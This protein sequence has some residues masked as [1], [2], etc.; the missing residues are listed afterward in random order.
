MTRSSYILTAGIF[1]VAYASLWPLLYG[2]P[3]FVR[4]VMLRLPESEYDHFLSA[5]GNIGAIFIML[6]TTVAP[7]YA[8]AYSLRN[9]EHSELVDDRSTVLVDLSVAQRIYQIPPCLMLSALTSQNVF[10]TLNLAILI[11]IVDVVGAYVHSLL[12]PEK[13]LFGVKARLKQWAIRKGDGWGAD[14]VHQ[15][16]AYL[17]FVFAAVAS[18]YVAVVGN[19]PASNI[20]VHLQCFFSGNWLWFFAHG[21]KPSGATLFVLLPVAGCLLEIVSLKSGTSDPATIALSANALCLLAGVISKRAAVVLRIIATLAL[22][23]LMWHA[24]STTDNGLYYWSIFWGLVT[25]ASSQ[26]W[27]FL[28]SDGYNTQQLKRISGTYFQDFLLALFQA[29]LGGVL[30]KAECPYD[31]A[32]PV[33]LLLPVV[34]LW[35]SLETKLLTH[36]WT[37]TPFHPSWAV[38]KNPGDPVTPKYSVSQAV[39]WTFS[40]ATV[41]ITA[42]LTTYA[43]YAVVVAV[44]SNPDGVTWKTVGAHG[45]IFVLHTGLW[46]MVAS[47]GIP[48]CADDTRSKVAQMTPPALPPF[49]KCDPHACLPIHKADL[50]FGIVLMCI[51]G[52][53]SA[54]DDASDSVKNAVW[55]LLGLSW[56]TT[57]MA[58]VALHRRYWGERFVKTKKDAK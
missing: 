57:I 29:G 55:L 11:I 7:M 4:D 9:G 25:F 18:I 14:G 8:Y 54:F 45:S 51:A 35:F 15:T 10:D 3:S 30:V 20:V 12:A 42:V 19:T 49:L 26:T 40:I 37:G 5:Q 17:T 58:K 21:P 56:L 48:R 39:N 43:A 28:F 46:M 6:F 33:G 38:P 13:G 22:Y 1:S 44:G 36:L 41:L 50:S 23:G 16:E 32:Y 47:S 52:L 53:T 27:R 34:T 2:M 24:V 31:V